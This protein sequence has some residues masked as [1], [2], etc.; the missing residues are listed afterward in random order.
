M[1]VK[2]HVRQRQRI[3]IATKTATMY[4]VYARCNRMVWEARASGQGKANPAPLAGT[5][6]EHGGGRGQ[7]EGAP[8]PRAST[9]GGEEEL[10]AER[11]PPGQGQARG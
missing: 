9:R 7:G 1:S 10:E 11:E 4:W 3:I 6:G 8:G 5:G 2:D